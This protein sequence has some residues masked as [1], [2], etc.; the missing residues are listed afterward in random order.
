MNETEDQTPGEQV[1]ETKGRSATDPKVV[2]ELIEPAPP[3]KKIVEELIEYSVPDAY[4]LYGKPTR[5]DRRNF[6]KKFQTKKPKSPKATHD[7]QTRRWLAILI[8]G[9]VGLINVGIFTSF[10]LGGITDDQLTKAVAALSGPQAL[11]AAAAG[12][13]YADRRGYKQN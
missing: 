13:Y 1:K 5:S 12:F 7:Q 11:A 6:P 3:G 10:L 2:E 9:L 4:S 8:L